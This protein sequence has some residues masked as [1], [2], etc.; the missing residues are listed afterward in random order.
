MYKVVVTICITIFGIAFLAALA[1]LTYAG[2]DTTDLI[3][4][5]SAILGAGGL[6]TGGG[7]VIFAKKAA[8]NTNGSLDIRIENGVHKVLDERGVI[9]NGGQILQR[10]RVDRNGGPSND[11]RVPPN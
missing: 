8:E 11:N 2:K 6:L 5:L 7:A 10:P 3:G 9:P 4:M 1:L